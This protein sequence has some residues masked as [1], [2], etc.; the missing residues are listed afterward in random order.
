MYFKFYQSMYD[1][2]LTQEAKETYN[3]RLKLLESKVSIA[4]KFSYQQLLKPV[5][6]KT[7]RDLDFIYNN[8]IDPNGTYHTD[9]K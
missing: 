7:V 1:V 8:L 6:L 3:Q 4:E 9:G 5:Y 2:V